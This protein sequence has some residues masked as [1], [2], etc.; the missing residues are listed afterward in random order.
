M[1]RQFKILVVMVLCVLCFAGCATEEDKVYSFD[2]VNFDEIVGED[3]YVELTQDVVFDA[4]I[5]VDYD[6]VNIYTLTAR[7]VE[8][9]VLTDIFYAN[10]EITSIE[11]REYVTGTVTYIYSGTDF[12]MANY[13]SVL[14]FEEEYGTYSDI[15]DGYVS[16]GETEKILYTEDFDFASLDDVLAEINVIF[17]ELGIIVSEPTCFNI[18][19]DANTDLQAYYLTYNLAKDGIIRTS[20]NCGVYTEGTYHMGDYAE[21]IYTANG[22][23]Y[24]YVTTLTDSHELYESDVEII[25]FEES[26]K[27]M[28]DKYNS[29]ILDGE[30]VITDVVLEYISVTNTDG[31]ETYNIVPMWIYTVEKTYY[32]E[33]DF[34]TYDDEV[35]S[36]YVMFDAITGLEYE[37][38]G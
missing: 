23:V 32:D 31:S 2:N 10:Q 38:E 34:K 27:L 37:Y 11:N 35:I 3:Y 9:D 4:T 21:V 6:T 19:P 33:Y 7:K 13:Y 25:S 12:L 8:A 28:T 14:Y 30:Y 5:P 17:D 22:I 20:L 29:Y 36:T 26:L 18:A 16:R 24:F 1:K 15:Y